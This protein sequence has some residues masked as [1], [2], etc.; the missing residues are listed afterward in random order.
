MHKVIETL[1]DL[2]FPSELTLLEIER[3]DRKRVIRSYEKVYS[4]VL[5]SQK[6]TSTDR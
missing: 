4:S 3:F 6:A 5:E 2:G 1:E